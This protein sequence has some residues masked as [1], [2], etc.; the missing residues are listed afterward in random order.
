MNYGKISKKSLE[1]KE[2]SKETIHK[3]IVKDLIELGKP[4]IAEGWIEALEEETPLKL[5]KVENVT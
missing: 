3:E 5:I 2:K 1:L 4:E